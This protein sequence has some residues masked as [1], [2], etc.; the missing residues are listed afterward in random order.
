MVSIP[1]IISGS[2]AQQDD[3]A[4]SAV[5]MTAEWSPLKAGGANTLERT[6]GR[7]TIPDG[8]DNDG[9]VT[10]GGG[11]SAGTFTLTK[12]TDANGT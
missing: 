8:Q 5:P 6:G 12:H 9:S 11:A 10:M 2:G 4:A 1:P 3:D 7:H